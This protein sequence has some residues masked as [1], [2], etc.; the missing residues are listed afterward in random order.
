MV[1]LNNI[2]RVLILSLTMLLCSVGE[3]RSV[4]AERRHIYLPDTLSV[5]YR[6]TDAVK[7]LTIERDTLSARAIWQQIIDSDS[8]YAPAL[9]YLSITDRDPANRLEYAHRA[10]A[11]DS[12]NKWYADNYAHH[13]I[14]E[15]L[16]S[17]SIPIYRRL[18]RLDPTNIVSYHALAIIYRYNEMPYSAIAVIDSAEMRIGYNYFLAG[19]KQDLLLETRQYQRAIKEGEYIISEHPYDIES[20]TRLAYIYEVSG[21]DSLARR[22]YEQAFLL[23]TTSIEAIT[24]ISDYY[25]RCGNNQRMLDYEQ[26]LFRHPALDVDTKLERLDMYMSNTQFYSINFT[27]IGGLIQDLAID[28]PNNRKVIDIYAQHLIY[29]GYHEVALE[30]LRLH[31]NDESVQPD[32]YIYIVGLEMYMDRLDLAEKDLEQGLERY[33]HDLDLLSGSAYLLRLKED[34]QGVIKLYRDAL[35]WADTAETQSELLGNIGDI[36]HELD[37]DNQAFKYYK[38]AL[39]LNPDNALVL[40]NYAYFL[41]L[42]DK[43]LDMALSMAER[44]VALEPRN[45]SYVDTYAWVLH[46]CGRNKEAKDVMRTAL[47]LSK[48]GEASLLMHYGDILWALGEKFMAET[49]WQKAIDRGYDPELMKEHILAIKG[50]K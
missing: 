17:R 46:R 42:L 45:A 49:Y 8:C 38:R 1:V 30:Y 26:Y 22:T 18:M 36:Y 37:D 23:D 29:G 2:L 12:M 13:L 39:K 15:R 7:M 27:R 25:S 32:D 4:A 33:P 16:Y 10:Y 44:A 6:H 20:R 3:S 14:N 5:T 48:Q 41:S 28:Y 31:L 24:A 43:K 19:F 50:Q 47:S 34:Y 9:Y 40:N 11:A 21:N 35:E